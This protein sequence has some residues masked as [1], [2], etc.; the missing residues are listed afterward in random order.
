MHLNVLKSK[1]HNISIVSEIDCPVYLIS[2]LFPMT[3]QIFLVKHGTHEFV[4]GQ[5]SRYFLLVKNT[6]HRYFWVKKYDT[7]VWG[8]GSV[9]PSQSHHW[10]L[11]RHCSWGCRSTQVMQSCKD[12]IQII[13]IEIFANFHNL[14]HSNSRICLNLDFCK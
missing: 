6:T 4:I 10:L 11:H 1:T 8:A 3:S 9:S 13:N 14:W 7:Q 12:E 5:T 2:K